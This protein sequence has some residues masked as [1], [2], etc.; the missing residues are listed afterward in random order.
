[1]YR[2]YRIH[3][4]NATIP[5]SIIEKAIPPGF[6][7]ITSQNLATARF[8]Q[9]LNSAQITPSK[10]E[11]YRKL[12]D[13]SIKRM[14]VSGLI[15]LRLTEAK[16]SSDNLSRFN[17]FCKKNNIWVHVKGRLTPS[18]TQTNEDIRYRS[19]V[20][21][22]PKSKLKSTMENDMGHPRIVNKVF[23]VLL[24]NA[25]II[26]TRPQIVAETGLSATQVTSA[27]TALCKRENSR[28]EKILPG[29]SW[30]LHASANHSA[31]AQ[32]TPSDSQPALTK[33]TPKKAPARVATRKEPL[34][35][36]TT[37]ITEAPEVTLSPKTV[38]STTVESQP[39]PSSNTRY[40]E[41]V[42][43]LGDGKIL[44]KDEEETF[45][46]AQKLDI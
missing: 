42:H 6:E 39:S 25:N 8:Y 1:M 44:I 31:S 43:D 30:I 3:W 29:F 45:Y 26:I 46:K 38:S 24:D 11:L 34:V 23:Q 19:Y 9:V 37:P 16:M 2:G 10:K 32:P 20:I 4:Q 40:F 13:F 17:N 12:W 36:T 7:P 35:I 41:L 28:V 21:I 33:S 14:L 27:M 5:E 15:V 18:Y 22:K